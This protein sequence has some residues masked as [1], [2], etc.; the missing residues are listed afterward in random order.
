MF[1][2]SLVALRPPHPGSARL[3]VGGWAVALLWSLVG[4]GVVSQGRNAE[5]VRQYTQGDFQGALET[6]QKALYSDPENSDAYYNLAATF[7]RLG[8]LQGQPD[9]LKQAESYYN[10]ALDRDPAH[11]DA[12]RGL[13]VLL[14][15]DQRSQDAFRLLEG[16]VERTPLDPQA[17][18][19]LAR[20]FEE[21]GNKEAAKEHLIQAVNI[22]PYNAQALAALGRIHEQL[23]NYGQALADY[24]RSLWYN[25]VQPELQARIAA[26]QTAANPQWLTASPAAP[27]S[28]V[29]ATATT[30]SNG[31]PA[32][33][34]ARTVTNPPT[35]TR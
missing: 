1:H 13:A 5:G 24:Q 16:W 30:L 29:A 32:A 10:Q 15:D 6:F 9:W 18:L 14:T 4:C 11:R 31:A 22:D 35:I 8:K 3:L 19:E 28:P 25:R 21:F 26:L 12:Y 2:S 23:G 27:A 17:R 7:H 20:L 33:E 34:P